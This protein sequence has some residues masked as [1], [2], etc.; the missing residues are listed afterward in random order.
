MLPRSQPSSERASRVPRPYTWM[1]PSSSTGTAKETAQSASSGCISRAGTTR[2]QWAQ[3][4]PVWCILAPRT[5]MPWL[6]LL[7]TRRYR[8]GS[9]CCDGLSERSPFTS[10]TPLKRVRSPACS[11]SM[12]ASRRVQYCVPC[13]R[14]QSYTCVPTAFMP[15]MPVQRMKQVPMR[16]LRNL[17]M[18]TLAMRSSALRYREVKRLTGSWRSLRV[19]R[20]FAP[21]GSWCRSYVRATPMTMGWMRG[22]S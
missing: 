15:S 17:S 14:S 2:P 19:T 5:T 18:C 22:C 12:K 20:Y 7:M 9:F 3:S 4:E 8:S 16:R 21:S 11:M 1:T 13:V 6:S 10:V